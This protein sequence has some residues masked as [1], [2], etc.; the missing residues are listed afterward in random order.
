MKS[1]SRRHPYRQMYRLP[2]GKYTSSGKKCSDVWHA[3]AD[4]FCR[5]TG[6][7]PHGFDPG[8]SFVYPKE[9][10]S[11]YVRLPEEVLMKLNKYLKGVRNES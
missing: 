2:N 4:P 7:I 6:M 10:L 11:Y 9:L 5:A 1:G 3:L 8:I